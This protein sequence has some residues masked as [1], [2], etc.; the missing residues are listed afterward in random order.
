[1]S[2]EEESQLA[3]RSVLGVEVNHWNPVRAGHRVE[4]FG[5]LLGPIIVQR[6]LAASGV[7][8]AADEDRPLVAVG[9]VL[10]PSDPRAVVWGAGVNGKIPNSEGSIPRS[11]DVRATRGPWTARYLRGLGIPVTGVYGDPASLTGRLFPELKRAWA[12]QSGVVCVPNFNDMDWMAA[13]VG[14]QGVA[15]VDPRSPLP[16]VLATIAGADLVIGSSL[17]AVVVAE[18]LGIP[19]R[20]IASRHEAPF[21]YLDYLAGSGRPHEMI[22]RDAATALSM[23]GMPEHE[24]DLDRLESAFPWDLWGLTHQQEQPAEDGPSDMTA[25]AAED[26]ISSWRQPCDP[27]RHELEAYLHHLDALV[28]AAHDVSS[29]ELTR[30]LDFR[31]WWAPSLDRAA[32]DRPVH[33]AL[34]LAVLRGPASVRTLL[35]QIHRGYSVVVYDVAHLRTG[36]LLAVSVGNPN[37][38][39]AIRAVTIPGVEGR[40]LR[41]DTSRLI[42]DSLQ[43]RIDI[44]AV[45]PRNFMPD[46]GRPA[47]LE[48]AD[49]GVIEA[50]MTRSDSVPIIA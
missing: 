8:E 3:S 26:W 22:A 33:R 39:N 19:A 23:G 17:H 36:G 42:V 6:L 14:T 25:A 12:P 2:A 45:V 20:F 50:E 1:M 21:K 34:D 13:E 48:L 5:D 31:R 41:I 15:V 44:D 9:S 30:V 10:H 37:P 35:T 29:E 47:T 24:V 16:D 7:R 27:S 46:P 28:L 32:F 18:S 38:L 49:G 4:N 40:D 43:T 11:L